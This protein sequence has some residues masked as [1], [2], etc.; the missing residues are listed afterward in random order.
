[1]DWTARYRHQSR[2]LLLPCWLSPRF[3]ALSSLRKRIPATGHRCIWV[4]QNGKHTGPVDV[5]TPNIRRGS[6][7]FST[8]ANYTLGTCPIHRLLLRQTW[9]GTRSPLFRR[10][11]GPWP[12][13]RHIRPFAYVKVHVNGSACPC[14]SWLYLNGSWIGKSS[15]AHRNSARR[16]R[17]VAPACCADTVVAGQTLDSGDPAS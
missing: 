3:R 16:T 9:M 8:M 4:G 7:I 11:F 14:C 5:N 6:I 17:G 15:L 1:M 13:A 12:L 2:S 10:R